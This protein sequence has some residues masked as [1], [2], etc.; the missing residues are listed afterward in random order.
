MKT[1][2]VLS[3]A[4]LFLLLYL[5]LPFQGLHF[6]LALELFTVQ[7]Q[8]RGRA[9]P[10]VLGFEGVFVELATLLAVN[11]V[12]CAR[13]CHELGLGGKFFGGEDALGVVGQRGLVLNAL[14]VFHNLPALQAED[15]PVALLLRPLE[16]SQK[17]F[18]LLSVF[19]DHVRFL[20]LVLHGF[21]I[22]YFVQCVNLVVLEYYIISKIF[23]IP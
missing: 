21:Q 10:T 13:D 8:L 6:F 5:L 23:H 3:G 16:V 4:L 1:H 17:G 7:K 11:A 12:H 20:V 15:V 22:E 9:A 19:L 14:L 18:P 2:G